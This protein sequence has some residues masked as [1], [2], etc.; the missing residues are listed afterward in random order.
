MLLMF[1]IEVLYH[2]KNLFREEFSSLII[3]RRIAGKPEELLNYM[4]LRGIRDLGNHQA[5]ADGN[6]LVVNIPEIISA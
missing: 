4:K 5:G 2:E 1:N 6:S 3:L